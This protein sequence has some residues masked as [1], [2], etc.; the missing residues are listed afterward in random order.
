MNDSSK[1]VIQQ[2][3][4]H[5]GILLAD[6]GKFNRNIPVLKY[7]V[8][9]MNKH[10]KTFEFEFLPVNFRDA[11]RQKS[12]NL[13]KMGILQKDEVLQKREIIRLSKFIRMFSNKSSVVHNPNEGKGKVLR[14]KRI[15]AFRASYQKY[16]R[17]SIKAFKMSDQELATEH[18][19]L[20]TTARFTN[21]FY[22]LRK[23]GFAILAL[24]NWKRA[25]APPSIIEFILTLILRQFYVGRT[26]PF[27]ALRV[28]LLDRCRR[29]DGEY[30]SLQMAG[31]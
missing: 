17:T 2:S 20:V 6:M 13:Q 24:G 28:T 22:S 9:Q 7:L 27:A 18:L 1:V 8:L 15:P 12:E 25:M 30:A 5:I 19:I 3:P 26:R 31:R 21:N 14:E 16:L 11:I 4:K 23:K 10:Q 29:G